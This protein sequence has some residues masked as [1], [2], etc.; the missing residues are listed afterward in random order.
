M[1]SLI[2]SSN[3]ENQACS[4]LRFSKYSLDFDHEWSAVDSI[5]GS[6]DCTDFKVNTVKGG[7]TIF[8]ITR[9]TRSIAPNHRALK[10][11]HLSI[12]IK[13][14]LPR[15]NVIINWLFMVFN[16]HVHQKFFQNAT[17]NP[18]VDL[19]QTMYFCIIYHFLQKN[20]Q[21][22]Y[23]R[24]IFEPKSGRFWKILTVGIR[25]VVISRV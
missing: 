19:V 16:E 18:K 11:N 20:T 7:P 13:L 24:A 23:F 12:Y 8:G 21:N 4:N 5:S 14:D 25:Q 2:T 10:S 15:V 17:R 9:S 3:P 22:C 6:A 1:L